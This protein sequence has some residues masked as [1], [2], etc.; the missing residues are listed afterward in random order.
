MQ[1]HSHLLATS[2]TLDAVGIGLHIVQGWGRMPPTHVEGFVGGEG[3][4][5]KRG[6]V[7]RLI[8]C[9]LKMNLKL[10]NLLFLFLVVPKIPR[11]QR[12]QR[13]LQSE[14]T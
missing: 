8:G 9:Q 6:S 14:L 11:H 7:H 12:N 10:S 13:A 1:L 3:T 2:A 5:N 4:Q